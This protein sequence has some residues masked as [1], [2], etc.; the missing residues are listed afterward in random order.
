M[1][2]LINRG[3]GETPMSFRGKADM[4]QTP[5]LLFQSPHFRI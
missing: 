2:A 4:D 1:E 3:M 5:M